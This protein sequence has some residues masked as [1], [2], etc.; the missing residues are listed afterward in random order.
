MLYQVQSNAAEM[1]AMRSGRLHVGGFSTGPTTFAVDIG[2]AVPFA[3][4]GY[5][6]ESWREE[7]ARKKAA[8]K[9]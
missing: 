7:E 9:K 1:E 2:C 5:E 3:M 4:K 6:K 8:E